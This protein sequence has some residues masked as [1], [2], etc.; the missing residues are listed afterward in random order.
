MIM[1][2]AYCIYGSRTGLRC[3]DLRDFISDYAIELENYYGVD[4]GEDKRGLS[5]FGRFDGGEQPC[6]ICFVD[7][8][9]R[10]FA[11]TNR[12]ALRRAGRKRRQKIKHRYSYENPMNRI[13]GYVFVEGGNNNL[14]PEDKNILSLSLICSSTFTDKKGIGSDMMEILLDGAKEVGFTD[15][16][17]EV[18]NEF[19]GKGQESEEEESDEED[20]EEE[21]AEQPEE[22]SDE[23]ESEDEEDEVW[24]PDE[25]ALEI[26]SHELWRKTMR[27][28]D[29]TPYYNV[30]KDYISQHVEEYFYYQ[31]YEHEKEEKE[32]IDVMDEPD[33]NEYGGFW[34]RKG[35]KSQEGLIGFY[36]KFGFV[37]EPKIHHEWNCYS[38]VPF[39][40]MI[41]SL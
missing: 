34:Y 19:S 32:P 29:D 15:I 3:M 6:I 28:K 31:D 27:F 13:H 2:K 21:Q 23:E 18:A 14:T 9:D 20:S 26:I 39:P 40:T 4:F 24:F 41:R 37:D 25:E 33:D 35:Y 30:D 8:E 12:P 10:T 1:K 38:R 5:D 7:E 17:L 22:E 36:K 11:S 16:I